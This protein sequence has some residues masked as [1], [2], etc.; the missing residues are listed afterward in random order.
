M[1]FFMS[2]LCIEISLVNNIID[3]LKKEAPFFNIFNDFKNFIKNKNI[4]SIFDSFEY[5]DFAKDIVS[6]SYEIKSSI[7]ISSFNSYFILFSFLSSLLLIFNIFEFS[8][9]ISFSS[10]IFKIIFLLLFDKIE[11]LFVFI[12]LIILL[13]L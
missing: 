7:N 6:L 1:I 8:F 12:I 4:L 13:F 10:I 2:L 11:K 9:F 3:L 5:I